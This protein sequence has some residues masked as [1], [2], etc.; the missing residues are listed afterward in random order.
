MADEVSSGGGWSSDAPVLENRAK[1]RGASVGRVV[2]R[3]FFLPFDFRSRRV[4]GVLE[5]VRGGGNEGDFENVDVVNVRSAI[6][7]VGDAALDVDEVAVPDFRAKSGCEIAVYEAAVP[8]RVLVGALTLG[9]LE[10]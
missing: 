4:G 7:E 2:R 3:P 6:D 8:Q 9:V 10:R 1:K 5:M